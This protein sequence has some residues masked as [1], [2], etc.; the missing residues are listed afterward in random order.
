MTIQLPE[1]LARFVQDEVRK[2]VFASEN[3]AIAEAIRL[4]RCQKRN[5]P[6]QTHTEEEFDQRLRAAGLLAATPSRPVS[7]SPQPPF[8]AIQINGQPLSETVIQERR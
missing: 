2:G 8:Q 6:A 5:A 1:D 3:E 7:S 4:L